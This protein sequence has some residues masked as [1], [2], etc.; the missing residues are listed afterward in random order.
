L[1]DFTS[2]IA[3]LSIQGE[4]RLFL[5]GKEIF[6][7]TNEKNDMWQMATKVSSKRHSEIRE[8]FSYPFS[9]H[10]SLAIKDYAG[11]G[12]YFL[13]DIPKAN[14]YVFFQK[15]IKEYLEQADSWSKI[16]N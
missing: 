5:F 15:I 2:I 8:F 16:L 1:R 3:E 9:A 4:G 7:F 11:R 14:R 12:I 10:G 6:V 13:Y